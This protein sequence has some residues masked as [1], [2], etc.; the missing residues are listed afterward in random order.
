MKNL[1]KNKLYKSSFANDV[2][3]NKDNKDK[4]EHLSSD[5]VVK[6]KIKKENPTKQLKKSKSLVTFLNYEM[7]YKNYFEKEKITQKVDPSDNLIDNIANISTIQKIVDSN[8]TLYHLDTYFPS[9]QIEKV[10]SKKRSNL[11]RQKIYLPYSDIY[12]FPYMKSEYNKVIYFDGKTGK[13]IIAD[14]NSNNYVFE[15]KNYQ[16]KIF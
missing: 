11:Y 13:E 15:E 9:N 7:F 5:N 8:D 3:S 2:N 14:N 16:Q 4:K 1:V 10:S 12:Y 6:I